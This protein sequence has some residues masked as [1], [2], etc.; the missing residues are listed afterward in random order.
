MDLADEVVQYVNVVLFAGLAL[1]CLHSYRRRP[2]KPEWWAAIAF[3]SIGLVSVAGLMFP[4]K[5]SKD[6]VVEIV[7][8]LFL[9]ALWVFPYALYRFTAAFERLP[10]RFD[11]IALGLTAGVELATVLM[12]TFPREGE[13]RP[14]WVEFYLVIV[15]VQWGL[16][17]A[18]AARRLWRAGRGLPGVA[19][20]RTRTL[21]LGAVGLVVSLLPATIPPEDQ[22]VAVRVFALGLPSLSAVLF[23]LGLSPPG[24]LRTLWRRSEGATLRRIE[25][26]LVRS[27]DRDRV[28]ELALA[29]VAA[30]VGGRAAVI[31]DPDHV[32]DTADTVAVPL[33][34]GTLVVELGPYTPFFGQDELEMLR[35]F[36]AFLDLVLDRTT[37]L[38]RERGSRLT[39]ERVNAELE[40]LVYG[41]SHDLKSPVISLLGYLEY[42]REDLGDV[43]ND[44]T[45]H[46]ITRMESSAL[47]MQ[48]LLADLL[49]LSRI[50]RVGVELADVDL[51]EVVDEIR[52]S[53][54]GSFPE[55]AVEVGDLPRLSMNPVRARQLFTNLL[56]NAA[57]HGGRPDVMVTVQGT[58]RTDGWGVI[59]VSDDGVGIPELYREKAFGIFERLTGRDGSSGTGIGLALCRKIVENAGGT[60]DIV[61]APRGTHIQIL[62]PPA[63][64]AAAGR[65][66]YQV[67]R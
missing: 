5:P 6:L 22:P 21:A 54:A 47:Y 25:L 29:Q 3:G 19:R 4:E 60:I 57:R 10:R 41:I 39:A 50:G 11:T 18:V 52:L 40:T 34:T 27:E 61:D 44:Q 23:L 24:W 64:M 1:V 12:P 15:L 37:L 56:E 38:E 59:S 49:E 65:P 63:A 30:L 35:S 67:V 9:L 2:A 20:L 62:F 43:L 42:L 31:D 7:L 16:L 28:I 36:A 26:E 14:L 51:G 55:A 17:S 32:I 8:R 46:F 45:R 58:V 33:S 13:A 53:L 66:S 48:D